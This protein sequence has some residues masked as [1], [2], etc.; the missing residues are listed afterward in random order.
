MS[1]IT[2]P[3]GDC[4]RLVL[5]ATRPIMSVN[6]MVTLAP[7]PE[8]QSV[9]FVLPGDPGTPQ[10]DCGPV[11]VALGLKQAFK[12]DGGQ[13]VVAVSFCRDNG[14]GEAAMQRFLSNFEA[15][16]PTHWIVET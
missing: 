8:L 3:C 2:V 7:L 6:W 15:P 14:R 10:Q 13:P 11:N 9:E 4:R 5:P 12:L 1:R 16:Q